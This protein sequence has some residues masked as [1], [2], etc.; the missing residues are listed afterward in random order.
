MKRPSVF[1]AIVFG[2]LGLNITIVTL[3]LYL[4]HSDPSFAV[5]PD[6]YQKAVAWDTSARLRAASDRLGWAAALEVA[7]HE[8]GIPLLTV[9]LLDRAGSPVVD[10]NVEVAAFA[11]ARAGERRL[12]SL[13]PA[14]PGVYVA[15]MP[16]AQTGQWE[17]GLT[18]TRGAERFEAAFE[19]RVPAARGSHP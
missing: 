11:S 13:L 18:A 17:F 14:E 9:R 2:L 3:T 7:P 12:I 4:A 19:R 6:Y 1:P 10:A 5:E 16:D 8:S 15:D